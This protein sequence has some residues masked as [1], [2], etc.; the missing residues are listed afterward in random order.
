M[1]QRKKDGLCYFCDDK[2]V[3]G[4]KCK[5]LFRMELVTDHEHDDDDAETVGDDDGFSLHALMALQTPSPQT[6]RW[7]PSA[8]IQE[9]A[10]PSTAP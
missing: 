6:S 8:R 3:P 2:Y 5:R 1:E 7:C 10:P 9:Y 4:H